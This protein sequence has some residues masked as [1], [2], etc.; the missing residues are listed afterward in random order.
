MGDFILDLGDP[1]ERRVTIERAEKFLSFCELIHTRVIERT[2]FSLLLA[3]VDGE[4]LW[5]PCTLKRG[6]REIFVALC[7]RVAIAEK[8]WDDAAKFEAEGG[9]ACRAICKQYL[10]S[11]IAG[12]VSLNGSYTVIIHDGGRNE[13]FL[14]TDRAGLSPVYYFL[15]FEKRPV[16]SSH[17]DLIALVTGQSQSWDLTS[18]AQFLMTGSVTFPFSYYA[19][20]R[21]APIGS[22]DS[23]CR[24]S[25]P[26]GPG[27]IAYHDFRPDFRSAYSETD[28]VDEL[29]AALLKAVKMRTSPRFGSTGVALSG[30]LDSRVI[31]AACEPGAHIRAFSLFDEINEEVSIAQRIAAALGVPLTLMQRDP[32]YYARSAELGV[33]ISGG[34]GSLASNHFLGAREG[35]YEHGFENLITGCYCDYLF[36]ALAQNTRETRFLRRQKIGEFEFQFYRRHYQISSNHSDAVLSRLR[37]R[38]PEAGRSNLSAEDWHSIES[39]RL[40]P[41]ATEGDCLQRMVPQRVMPWYPLVVDTGLLEVYKHIPPEAKLNTSLFRSMM[42]RVCA[43]DLLEIEDAN[44]GAPVNGGM[45][46]LLVGRYKSA[47]LDRWQRKRKRGLATRG[48]WPNR[49]YFIHNNQTI[50]VLW[51]RPN[52]MAGELLSQISGS[53]YRRELLEYRGAD[54]QFFWRLLTLKIWLDQRCSVQSD[55]HQFPAGVR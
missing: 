34:C 17:P 48:S 38:F 19:K 41:L 23:I 28:L 50:R 39:R 43:P 1:L 6:G 29:S 11:G 15:D 27:S 22:I 8:D 40:F 3:S 36:K 46:R 13:L 14:V 26:F 54:T 30:G 20:V 37:E 47:L 2:G 12:L 35:F 42:K 51:E 16:A 24:Y 55:A 5:S 18:F 25:K 52:P 33:R 9:L 31:L 53:L 45:V 7:G 44:T 49:E 4:E 32:E 21:M 10:E